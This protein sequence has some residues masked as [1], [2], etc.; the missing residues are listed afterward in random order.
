MKVKTLLK[1]LSQL[2]QD[3]DIYLSSD[4]EGNWFSNP[5]SISDEGEYYILFPD[6]AYIELEDIV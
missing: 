5:D 1:I 4:S 3:K 2:G 6:D